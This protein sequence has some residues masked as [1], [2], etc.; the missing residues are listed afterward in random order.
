MK[1][2]SL[3]EPRG[4]CGAE[5]VKGRDQSAAVK[6]KQLRSFETGW[7]SERSAGLDLQPHTHLTATSATPPP[8]RLLVDVLDSDRWSW[9]TFERV[10]THPGESPVSRGSRQ[11]WVGVPADRPGD[12]GLYWIHSE[13]FWLSSCL[14]GGGITVTRAG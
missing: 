8:P 5:K 14:W 1:A 9:V 12:G 11:G 6:R 10:L 7:N 4:V 2:R 13:G 3:A